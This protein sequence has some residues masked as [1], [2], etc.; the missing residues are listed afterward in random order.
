MLVLVKT[1]PDNLICSTRHMT[2]QVRSALPAIDDRP[3]PARPHVAL[4]LKK[5]QRE[6]ERKN[7]ILNDN[8]SLLQRLSGIMKLSR[9]DNHW[10]RPLPK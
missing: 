9:L 2:V 8:F 5:Q 4:K 6:A 3:P 10:V 1:F 7:K